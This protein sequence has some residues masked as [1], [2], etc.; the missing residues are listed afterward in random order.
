MRKDDR[1]VK[2]Q[3]SFALLFQEVTANKFKRG[4]GSFE[5]ALDIERDGTLV[6][7][8]VFALYAIRADIL[9]HDDAGRERHA[10]IGGTDTLTP[11]AFSDKTLLAVDKNGCD[12]RRDG[13]VDEFDYHQESGVRS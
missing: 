9:A 10:Q 1:I 6:A 11:S 4:G 13:G 5:N 12:G 8:D 3:C 2:H 7:L